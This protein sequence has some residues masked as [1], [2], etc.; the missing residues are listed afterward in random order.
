M[1]WDL[2]QSEKK[3]P[4]LV[5]LMM[6]QKEKMLEHAPST[7]EIEKQLDQPKK[8]MERPELMPSTN[9]MERPELVSP[10]KETE[11]S[12]LFPLIEEIIL[13]PPTDS[14][15]L[16]SSTKQKG[17]TLAQPTKQ[18]EIE[19]QQKQLRELEL[20]MK[21]MEG[22]EEK[23]KQKLENHLQSLNQVMKEG[24]EKHP[25]E[26]K[27]KLEYLEQPLK[28]EDM[29]RWQA[30]FAQKLK[31]SAHSIM[32]IARSTERL[33]ENLAKSEKVLSLEKFAQFAKNERV[34]KQMKGRN[35]LASIRKLS[36]PTNSQQVK[37]LQ[38][39]ANFLSLYD[40]GNYPHTSGRASGL[41]S[42]PD[43]ILSRKAV[44]TPS[45]NNWTVNTV[46]STSTCDKRAHEHKLIL[47]NNNQ[48][49]AVCPAGESS[50]LHQ[51][52]ESQLSDAS[53][54]YSA[55]Y[56]WFMNIDD[57]DIMSVGIDSDLQSIDRDV[58]VVRRKT[59]T[60]PSPAYRQ[61]FY[62]KHTWRYEQ[63]DSNTMN[64]CLPVSSQSSIEA[65]ES[66]NN[67]NT[68]LPTKRTRKLKNRQSKAKDQIDDSSS[69]DSHWSIILKRDLKN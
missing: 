35:R 62:V 58:C 50:Y 27:Q 31:H 20:L 53:S 60:D 64:L 47:I 1:S 36:I 61:Q 8:Q 17:L 54:Y 29:K 21:G 46:Q 45:K 4:E 55:R 7:K 39:M 57:L 12:E 15:D 9:K 69:N 5:Q 66:D 49:S 30:E 42:L 28:K 52:S 19:E 68:C 10:T 16:E 34:L 23:L 2:A 14:L 48:S 11:R 22:S 32:K 56:D 67:I 40:H 37:V 18:V 65:D 41:S 59:M 3:G 63:N 6:K 25:Q 24:L 33:K 38:T 44:H 43:K 51:D 13:V 26:V